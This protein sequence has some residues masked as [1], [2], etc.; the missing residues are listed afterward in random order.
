MRGQ[1]FCDTS[2]T[3]ELLL[4]FPCTT[5][6]KASEAVIP[7]PPQEFTSLMEIMIRCNVVISQD[8]NTS[9]L[10]Q[11]GVTMWN[12]PPEASVVYISY[13]TSQYPVLHPISLDPSIP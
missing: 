10:S 4:V 6:D 3:G 13:D 9:R 7:Y 5:K 12:A 8:S 1:N 11:I 2:S